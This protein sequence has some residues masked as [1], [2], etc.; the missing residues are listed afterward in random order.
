MSVSP[1]EKGTPS[2]SVSF[3][4]LAFA[5]FMMSREQRQTGEGELHGLA[6]AEFEGLR[7]S[8]E[9]T[10]GAIVDAWWGVKLAGLGMALTVKAPRRINRVL[11]NLDSEATC[12]LHRATE[13]LALPSEVEAALSEGDLL[14]VKASGV[15]HG[16]AGRLT[17]ERVMSAQTYLL[18]LIDANS[19]EVPSPA[20]PRQPQASPETSSML[21]REAR[22][23]ASAAAAARRRAEAAAEAEAAE[24][25]RRAE[26]AE[27][28]RRHGEH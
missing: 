9:A 10:E 1:S 11:R 26:A 24:A 19:G 25:R 27:A 2:V 22:R 13:G 8:F 23:L 7:R 17:L 12:R 5:H 20:P 18:S 6:Q 16:P 21:L 4:E 14:A 15:L 3:A 28:A